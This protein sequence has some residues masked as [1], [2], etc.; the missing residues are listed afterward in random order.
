MSGYAVAQIDEVD[1]LNDGRVPWRPIRFHFGITSFGVNAFTAHQVGD[2]LINEHD[3]SQEHDLQ[4]ELYLVQRG[5][6]TFELG[7]LPLAGRA[8]GP[9]RLWPVLLV[10]RCGW[11]RRSQRRARAFRLSEAGSTR[12]QTGATKWPSGVTGA[13]HTSQANRPA[14]HSRSS[15][16]FDVPPH[17][18]VGASRGANPQAPWSQ[19]N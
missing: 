5:R 12:G 9:R 14:P 10:G 6:A 11:G 15:A 17:V 13:K 4:E 8:G 7:C 18:G 16:L 19:T 1:E 2:R 3:E